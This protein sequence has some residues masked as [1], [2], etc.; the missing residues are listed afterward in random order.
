MHRVTIRGEVGGAAGVQPVHRALQWI[1]NS[2]ERADSVC[3]AGGLRE[4]GGVRGC[5]PDI[6][7]TTYI[8][9]LF[10]QPSSAHAHLYTCFRQGRG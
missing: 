1:R 5:Q 2:E 10:A 8:C 4:V 6:K 9:S 7:A 3:M